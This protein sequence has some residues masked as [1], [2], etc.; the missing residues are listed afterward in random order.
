M[1]ILFLLIMKMALEKIRHRRQSLGWSQEYLAYELQVSIKTYSKLERGE[2]KLTL[3]RFIE[4]CHLLK[5]S[6]SQ[7]VREV[8]ENYS[9]KKLNKVASK[10]IPVKDLIDFLNRY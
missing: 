9:P 1:C 5:L 4:I 8:E 2:T 3:T 6:P 7:I 10:K